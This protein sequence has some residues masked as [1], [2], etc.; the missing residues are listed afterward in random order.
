MLRW[1]RMGIEHALSLRITTTQ[2]WKNWEQMSLTPSV[3]HCRVAICHQIYVFFHSR[4]KF[5]RWQQFSYLPQEMCLSS[6]T[7][8]KMLLRIS[9]NVSI[10]F[11]PLLLVIP[12]WAILNTVISLSSVFISFRYSQAIIISPYICLQAL[13]IFPH[14][15]A[16]S[17][18]FSLWRHR[19]E[20][21]GALHFSSLYGKNMV[22]L[23]KSP[24]R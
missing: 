13:L 17:S 20:Y 1:S 24:R 3:C 12:Y 7:A 4:F 15:E 10:I 18:F 21:K 8:S 16:P 9:R 22:H 19:S 6:N 11:I 2:D 5:P 14:K 23:R